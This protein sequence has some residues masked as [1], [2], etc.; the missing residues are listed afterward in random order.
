MSAL[1]AIFNRNGR[2]V[3]MGECGQMINACPERGPDGRNVIYLDNVALGHQLFLLLPEEVNDNQPLESD[4]IWLTADVRLD[5]RQELGRHLGLSDAEIVTTSDAWLILLA[6]RR[7]GDQCPERLLGDFAFIIWDNS[8]RRL[9]A[10]RDSLGAR[11][12]CYYFDEERFLIASEISHILA[13]PDIQ[14]EINDNRVAAYLLGMWDRPEETFYRDINYLSPAHAISVTGDRVDMWRYWGAQPEKIRYRDE[15]Q[16]AE[17]Y[18]DLLSEAVRCRLRCVGKVGISLS[19][20]LDSTFLAALAVPQLAEATGQ[21]RLKS[22]SYSFDELASCD[23][24]AYIHPVVE[25]YGLEAT[26]IPCDDL[27]A[28]KDLANWPSSRDYVISDTFAWL[29]AAVRTKANQSGIRALFA[30]YYGD[31]LMSGGHYWA[32][33][34][35]REGKFGPLIRT[36]QANW[37]EF[38]WRDS[39]IDFGLR[40]LV[41]PSVART[42]RSVRPRKA[43]SIAPGIHED[44]P[45]RTDLSSRLSPQANNEK[46]P[47]GFRQRY[48][49]LTGSN[50]SHNVAIRYQYNNCGMELIQPYYDRRLVE[51]VLSVP[52]YVLGRPGSFRRLHRESMSGL[53]PDEVRLRRR[54]TS[55]APLIHKGIERE[56]GAIR[57]LMSNPLVVRWGYIR[58]DWLEK[59]LKSNY[60]PSSEWAVLFYSIFLELWLQR[61]WN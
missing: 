27:W 41:P 32:L 47:P 51:F 35:A 21:K 18:R 10:A 2:P 3:D 46:T 33:D 45:A 49:T 13:H 48:E 11:D 7:W 22:F 23:E 15:R 42:Y 52:A 37:D 8:R 31:A 39:F 55:F 58:R 57:D 56:R 12:L 5:N 9:F 4:G 29:P 44:L 36:A 60:Q 30:G 28:F 59:M 17:H 24:S 1:V 14:P 40:R 54:R 16:Y 43:V 61:Y 38:N 34:M 19:G 26:Y 25:R 20:G 6:Y 50:F 53:L